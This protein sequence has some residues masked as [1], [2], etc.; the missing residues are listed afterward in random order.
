MRYVRTILLL[1]VLLALV[2]LRAGDRWNVRGMGMARTILAGSRGSE[3][4]GIN[5]ANLA[6]PDRSS[7]TLSLIRAGARFSTELVSY[8]IYQEY[9]TGVPGTSADGKREPK[10]LTNEDKEKILN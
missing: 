2:D 8:D 10:Y 9:F 6:I 5:P 7:F 4:L 1:A 3:A